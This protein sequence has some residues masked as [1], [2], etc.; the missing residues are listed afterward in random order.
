MKAG[1]QKAEGKKLKAEISKLKA[2]KN[3]PKIHLLN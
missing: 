3:A 2:K 1:R